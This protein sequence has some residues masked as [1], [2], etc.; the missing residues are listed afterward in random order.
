MPDGGHFETVQRRTEEKLG[1]PKSR[2]KTNR[3][4]LKALN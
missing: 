2:L 3:N 1:I 4:K